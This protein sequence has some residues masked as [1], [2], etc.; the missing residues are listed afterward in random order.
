ME[1]QKMLRLVNEA[2]K[3]LQPLKLNEA[4]IK[5]AVWQPRNEQQI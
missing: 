4:L 2:R 3:G 1:I 5:A